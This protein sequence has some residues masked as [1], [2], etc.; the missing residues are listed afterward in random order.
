MKAIIEEVYTK[1]DI[2]CRIGLGHLNVAADKIVAMGHSFGGITAVNTARKDGR[3]KAILAYDPW[4]Y[5][6]H[7]EC[8]LGMLKLERPLFTVMTE[9]FANFS[10]NF[11]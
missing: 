10:K 7:N 2:L 9:D 11:N 5:L 3:I 8:S 6:A 1:V 4:M